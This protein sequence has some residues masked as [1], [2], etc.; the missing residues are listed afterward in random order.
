MD[1]KTTLTLSWVVTGL[2]LATALWLSLK[3]NILRDLSRVPGE[4]NKP[5]SFAR[6][7]LM[8]WTVLIS[9]AYVLAFGYHGNFVDIPDGC[10]VLLGISIGTTLAGRVI[11]TTQIENNP[12][13]HQDIRNK[14][15]LIDILSDE[16]GISVH[17]FQ[18]LVFNLIFGVGFIV[19]FFTNYELFDFEGGQLTL[20]GISAS[21]YVGLKIN[22][23]QVKDKN[24]LPDTSGEDISL[25]QGSLQ[26]D[27]IQG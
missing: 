11:D 8:W 25:P 16:N 6:T 24:L 20:M 15:F 7:Q 2:I 4:T 3:T 21:A 18:A 19:K 5:Y 14:L 26:D 9:S 13:R 1:P 12:I 17:R 22:E 27:F 10:L 23:N